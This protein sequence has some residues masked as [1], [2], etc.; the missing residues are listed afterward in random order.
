MMRAAVVA[1]VLALFGP[2]SAAAQD[3]PV[4]A[5]TV[6]DGRL[7]F[8][9]KATLGDFTGVTSTVTGAVDSAASLAEVRGWVEAPVRT[10][11]TGNNHRDRDLNKSM[12]SDKYPVLRFEL[13]RVEAGGGGADSLTAQLHGRLVLHGVTRDVIL[14]ATIWIRPG[15]ARVTTTFP[16]NLKDYGIGGLTRML[17]T[18]RMNEHIVVHVDLTFQL[19]S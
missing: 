12:E 17:G 5:G 16:V 19:A 13:G 15:L 1:V 3:R 11:V 18:L 6:R 10:L 7:S 9:G 2:G 4:A 14:P 8:D